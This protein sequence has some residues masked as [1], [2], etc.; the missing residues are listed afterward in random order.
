M[1]IIMDIVKCCKKKKKQA[2]NASDVFNVMK[3]SLNSLLQIFLS[4]KR[5]KHFI[6]YET[7]N[8]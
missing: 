5:G 1:L 7:F 8:S 3:K 6:N 4:E 2:L